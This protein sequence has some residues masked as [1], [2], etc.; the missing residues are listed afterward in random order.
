MIVMKNIVNKI[1]IYS[2]IFSVFMIAV[3]CQKDF[4]QL[5]PAEYP[6]NPEIFLDGFSAGLNYSAFANSDVTA[7][8]VDSSVY[9]YGTKS[10]RVEVPDAESPSGAYA[11]GAF[12]TNIGR[13]L[14]DYTTLSF[15]IKS[16]KA[17]NIDI[18]GFGNYLGD[19]RYQASI[20]NIAVNTN[21]KKVYIPIP[22]PSLLIAEKGMFFFS[23]GPEDG[24]GYTFWIDNLQFEK[25]NAISLN[26]AYI[27]NGNDQSN[28][29]FTGVSAYIID[30]KSSFIL[31][32]GLTQ[33]V[34]LTPYYFS[35]NSSDESVAT[36][37]KNG[38]VTTVGAG[39]SSITATLGGKSALGSLTI[40]SLGVFTAAPTPTVDPSK[41][42]SIFSDTYTNHPVD[43]YNGYWQPYQTT[44][45]A[46]FVVEND[47]VLNYTNFNFVGIQMTSPTVDATMTSHLHLDIFI[48]NTI[49]PGS[50]L[51][52]QVIDLGS[53]G[54]FG[55]EDDS[56]QDNIID[57]SILKS[58][59]WISIDL[60]F[61]SMTNLQSRANLAQIVFVGTNIPNFYA[62]NIYFYN[63]GSIIPLTPETA[64]PTPTH[65]PSSVLSI[66]SDSYENIPGTD[67]NPYWGQTT[68]VSQISINGE[69]T[70]RYGN[71]NY[72]GTQLSS[73]INVSE[74]SYLHIDYYTANSTALNFFLI[75][76]GPVEKHYSLAVPSG[77]GESTNGWKS[78]DIPLSQFSSVDLNNIFQFKID[79][80]GDIY[81]DNIYFRK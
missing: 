66:F 11:G 76:P 50:T 1:I 81:F 23:E 16:S 5:E 4:D 47:H 25:N 59:E 3:S 53:N 9:Y 19:N 72:Q 45:S 56:T 57:P 14:S 60:P 77:I 36:V 79:G 35:F 49:D 78:I 63:D 7:F 34:D 46:D 62:D 22:D 26:E 12:F 42:I 6:K 74:Y 73:N 21:W 41:V 68:Q 43:Y 38:D 24:R 52:I 40:N 32:N 75:S 71:L 64:A 30:Q 28:I 18:L 48:P 65:S 2:A 80:N 54:E 10:I 31:P 70:L 61:S 27:L 13:D 58:N 8:Q 20:S 44:N 55:G 15:W 39:N 37:N 69:N 29:S 51:N 67:F 17:A 33:E